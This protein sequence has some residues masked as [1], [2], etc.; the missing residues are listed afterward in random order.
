MKFYVAYS[1]V[2]HNT[3]DMVVVKRCR[4]D[5]AEQVEAQNKAEAAIRQVY[6]LISTTDTWYGR[7]CSAECPLEPDDIY[8]NVHQWDI[9]GEH[10]D[11]NW[12]E[13]SQMPA[14]DK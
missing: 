1:V 8:I 13:I 10:L 14:G 7:A 2:D 9:W 11:G 5:A 6:A 12:A 3:D 4:I